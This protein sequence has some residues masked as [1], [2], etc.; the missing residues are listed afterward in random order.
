MTTL[1]PPLPFNAMEYA[2]CGTDR[3]LYLDPVPLTHRTLYLDP[4]CLCI[5]AVTSCLP[6]LPS[7]SSPPLPLA[8]SL[9]S[10]MPAP[11]FFVSHVVQLPI[12]DANIRIILLLI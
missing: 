4:A 6:L 8:L 1:S 7:S 3:T 10:F 11:P 9:L 2:W 5:Y 12:L